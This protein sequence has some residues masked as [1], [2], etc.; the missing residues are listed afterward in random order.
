MLLTLAGRALAQEA[1][2]CSGDGDEPQSA[3]PPCPP[4]PAPPWRW[5][6]AGLALAAIALAA[7]GAWYVRGNER[8][9]R[10]SRWAAPPVDP[11]PVLAGAGLGVLF[12]LS[13]LVF[14][15]PVGV[16]GGV[17]Q[18]ATLDLGWPAWIVLG[19]IAGGFLSA[20]LRRG[21]RASL[22]PATWAAQHGPSVAVR[23]T[24][25]FLAAAL[26]EIAGLVAGG[27]TSGLALSGGMV[28]APGAFVFMAAMF[29]GGV[30]A[31][32]LAA[33]LGRRR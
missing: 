10:A 33:R 14:R 7:G 18:L 13:L 6:D 20:A 22:V 27:C 5:A 30:P 24:V 11:A 1:V 32:G 29:A 21:L 15:R 3:A 12:A 31:A 2:T 23:W 8:R 25:T 19:V 9:R 26:V 4:A 28:L 16:S 17:R